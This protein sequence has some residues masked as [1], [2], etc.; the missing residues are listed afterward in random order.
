MN[1]YLAFFCWLLSCAVYG[2]EIDS[3]RLYSIPWNGAYFVGIHPEILTSN[4]IPSYQCLIKDKRQI[5][6][7][8][9]TV[10]RFKV[11]ESCPDGCPLYYD[12]RL[13]LVF[14]REGAPSKLLAVDHHKALYYDGAERQFGEKLI[15]VLDVA[16]QKSAVP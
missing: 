10:Q 12:I 8:E 15:G 6:K 7:I 4:A 1:V 3:I 16:C 11:L 2:Q 9:R 13:L 14:Y 5:R